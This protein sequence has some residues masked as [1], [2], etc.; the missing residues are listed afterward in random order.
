MQ[1]YI[2][3]TALQSQNL[4]NENTHITYI[5]VQNFIMRDQPFFNGLTYMS[6]KIIKATFTQLLSVIEYVLL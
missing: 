6:T 5:Q 3:N 2:Q 4:K 1:Y